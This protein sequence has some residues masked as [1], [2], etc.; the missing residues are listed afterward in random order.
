MDLGKRGTDYGHFTYLTRRGIKMINRTWEKTKIKPFFKIAQRTGGF[1]CST[2]VP[3]VLPELLN[4]DEYEKKKDKA[5]SNI[6][7]KKE[8]KKDKKYNELRFKLGAMPVDVRK[9]LAEAGLCDERTLRRWASEG[10]GRSGH[11]LKDGNK[12]YAQE[13][14]FDEPPSETRGSKDE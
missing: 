13:N 9:K 8:T 12:T 2:R 1:A 3:Y 4:E 6:G 11:G 14:D 7:K 10:R 5:I